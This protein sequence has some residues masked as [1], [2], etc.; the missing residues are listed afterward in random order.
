MHHMY[1]NETYRK[2]AGWKL[3]KNAICYFEQILE[4][5]THKTTVLWLPISHLTN[6]QHK[7]NKTCGALLEMEGQIQKQ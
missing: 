1:T 2:K 6:L 7:M 4:A 5:T 3:H